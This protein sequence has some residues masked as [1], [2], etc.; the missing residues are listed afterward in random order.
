[1]E[2]INLHWTTAGIINAGI[3]IMLLLYTNAH[4]S[5]INV[6]VCM[7]EYPCVA[8]YKLTLKVCS[9]NKSPKLLPWFSQTN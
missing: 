6:C 2:R 1:M 8:L 4:A 7:G 5:C 3:H 9:E